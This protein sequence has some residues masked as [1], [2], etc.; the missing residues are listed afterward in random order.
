MND[1][2]APLR[3]EK[4]SVKYVRRMAGKGSSGPCLQVLRY[5]KEFAAPKEES[6]VFPIHSWHTPC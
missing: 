3:E 5:T 4:G 1:P 6:A 2:R